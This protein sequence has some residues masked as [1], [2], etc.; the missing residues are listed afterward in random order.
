MTSRRSR[1]SPGAQARIAVEDFPDF[2]HRGIMIDTGRRFWPVPLVK[3]VIDVM[4]FNK[5][6]VLHLHASDMCRVAVE[7]KLF[8]ELTESLGGIKEGHYAQEDIVDLIAYGRD[9]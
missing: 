1:S 4:S 7:S 5:L 9:R 3:N 6:N 8:P 2:V